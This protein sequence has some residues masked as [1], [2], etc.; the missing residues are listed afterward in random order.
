MASILNSLEVEWRQTGGKQS[1]SQKAHGDPLKTLKVIGEAKAEPDADCV[2]FDP[3]SKR[4][5]VMNGRSH[6]STVIDAR[7]GT[8]VGTIDMGGAPEFEVAR[9]GNCLRQYRR[10][11]RGGGYRFSHPQD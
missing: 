6:S 5:F 2:I 8:V 3:A 11:E 9:P 7:S 10:D 4:I 1:K